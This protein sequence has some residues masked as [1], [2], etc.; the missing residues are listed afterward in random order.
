MI[1][2]V[3]A[4]E[5]KNAKYLLMASNDVIN[6][7]MYFAGIWEPLTL[8]VT[9]FLLKHDGRPGTV[10]DAGANM[11]GF[12]VPLARAL[13][14]YTFHSFEMQRI[15]Y[16]QLCGTVFL[17]S[18]ENVYCHNVGLNDTDGVIDIPIPEY[19]SDLNIGAVSLDPGV[20]ETRARGGSSIPAPTDFNP[21]RFEPVPVRPL[22]SFGLKDVRLI[23]LDV[24]GVEQRV[25]RG[26][27]QTLESSGFPPL[28]FEL[29]TK[30]QVPGMVEHENEL[31]AYV[32]SL[33]YV[34]QIIYD[35]AIAQHASR[36][37]LGFS[38]DQSANV[39]TSWTISNENGT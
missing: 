4:I 13:P 28:L 35:L 19:S 36:P 15:I 1:P 5:G 3:D 6:R 10:I 12:S 30:E 14:H 37:R 8:S 18:L 21:T 29:W 24:E 22:D 16:Y 20:R 33:G 39:L 11:G 27:R 7:Y 31:T 38:L 32:E 2:R 26:A 34:I 9:D 17:N 23:K 25:L